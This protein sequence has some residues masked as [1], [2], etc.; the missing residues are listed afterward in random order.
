MQFWP[1]DDEEYGKVKVTQKSQS[2]KKGY[3]IYKFTVV[4]EA[5]AVTMV[6]VC[7]M[8]GVCTIRIFCI[9]YVLI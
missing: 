1:N 8:F 3:I 9:C 5:T 4:G 7:S 6:S 2:E